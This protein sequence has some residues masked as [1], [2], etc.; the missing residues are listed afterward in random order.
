MDHMDGG[1]EKSVQAL[2]LRISAAF[3]AEAKT[4][5]ARWLT[6]NAYGRKCFTARPE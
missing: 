6:L 5:I 3:A 1:N 2:P 4:A